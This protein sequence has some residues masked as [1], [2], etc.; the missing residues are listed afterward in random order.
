MNNI[1][2]LRPPLIHETRDAMLDEVERKLTDELHK[3]I[4]AW[5][6]KLDGHTSY[7]QTDEMM[8]SV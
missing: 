1:N 7:L 2:S 6:T 5:K 8:S 3:A 4:N